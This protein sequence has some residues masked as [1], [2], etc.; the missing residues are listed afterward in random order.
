MYC[1]KY[2][3]HN[4]N[5]YGNKIGYETR[6]ADFSRGR[7]CS[8]CGTRK[9]HWKDSLA[10]NYPDI[11]KMIAIHENDLTFED[12]YKLG[13]HSEKINIILNAIYVT[14]YLIKNYI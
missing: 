2:N 8:Y 6:C 12:C 10:Y 13:C 4:Y 5:K 11:A 7:R 9:T 1:L 14:Q 3:Y